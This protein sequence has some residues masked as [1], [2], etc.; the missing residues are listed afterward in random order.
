MLG[1]DRVNVDEWRLQAHTSS[2]LLR[3]LFVSVLY[4]AV[5]LHVLLGAGETRVKEAGGG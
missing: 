1:G 2:E 3:L 5:Y 4:A